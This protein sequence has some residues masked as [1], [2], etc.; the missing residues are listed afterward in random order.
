MSYEAKGNPNIITTLKYALSGIGLSLLI[1]MI[2]TLGITLVLDKEVVTTT[3][4]SVIAAVTH[5]IAAAIG[6]IFVI[7]IQKE[8][9]GI[10]MAMCAVGY[11]LVWL[12]ISIFIYDGQ[13][14]NL[15][16]AV[17]AILIGNGI[18]LSTHIRGH[19]KRKYKR[20]SR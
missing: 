15:L 10:L 8:K 14:P 5:G 20:A 13:M 18:I 6:G 9:A 1:C 7:K 3:D 2:F 12:T 17:I 11:L 19:Q 4:L 16:G